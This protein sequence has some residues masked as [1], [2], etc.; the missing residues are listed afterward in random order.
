MAALVM[1]D[2]HAVI[3]RLEASGFSP[4][5]AEGLVAEQVKFMD[6]GL[7]TKRD[8]QDN[9]QELKQDIKDLRQ[10]LKQE[11]NEL[12]QEIK[13]LEMR[14]TIKLGAMMVVMIGVLAALKLV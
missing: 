4:K 7:A 9:K 11:I 1:F 14:L 12:R 3:T 5:Q 13:T 2:T 8:L 10:E 6:D